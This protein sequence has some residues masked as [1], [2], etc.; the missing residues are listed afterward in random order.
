MRKNGLLWSISLLLFGIS[1][2]YFGNNYYLTYLKKDPY[3]Y[4]IGYIYNFTALDSV[5]RHAH[6]SLKG[7]YASSAPEIYKGSKYQFKKRVLKAY[8]AEKYHDNGY[9]NL[10]FYISN[11]GKVWLY[12]TN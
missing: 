12:E 7:F 2:G 6:K 5:E 10:R 9:L 8:K 11:T 3:P 1:L 4:R